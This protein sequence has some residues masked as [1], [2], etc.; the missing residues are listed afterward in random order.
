VLIVLLAATARAQ[1]DFCIL[2]HM[3]SDDSV[4]RTNEDS[5]PWASK[6]LEDVLPHIEGITY[7]A[8]IR[9]A[10][11]ARY[12]LAEFHKPSE[13][14]TSLFLRIHAGEEITKTP[15]LIAD[16]EIQLGPSSKLGMD[17]KI[18]DAAWREIVAGPVGHGLSEAATKVQAALLEELV[19]PGSIQTYCS[20]IAPATAQVPQPI[21]NCVTLPL[22]WETRHGLAA[23][24]FRIEALPAVGIGRVHLIAEAAGSC[25]K[26]WEVPQD[27]KPYD[28]IPVQPKSKIDGGNP[29]PISGATDVALPWRGAAFRVETYVRMIGRLCGD[30]PE[31]KP[32]RVTQSVTQK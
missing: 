13:T 31:V 1:A 12:L 10:K 22:Q 20:E 30:L 15:N 5:M 16:L 21:E 8:Y 26:Y 3:R 11:C 9:N 14:G 28:A 2:S 17:Q 6:T 29:R 32:L 27:A 23:S 24:L 19:F 7:A 25:I 18:L 4:V